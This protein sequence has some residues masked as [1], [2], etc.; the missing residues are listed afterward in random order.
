MQIYSIGQTPLIMKIPTIVMVTVLA[1]PALAFPS[2]Q[3]G[4]SWNGTKRFS[5]SDTTHP[6]FE[7]VDKRYDPV[8]NAIDVGKRSTDSTVAIERSLLTNS[9]KGF[10][11]AVSTTQIISHVWLFWYIV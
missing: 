2:G 6:G 4:R 3:S 1:I 10:E 9:S 5:M 8:I 11:W 7:S